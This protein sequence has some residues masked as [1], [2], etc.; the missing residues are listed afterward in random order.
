M[1]PC[2]PN[3][4][5]PV[6]ATNGAPDTARAGRPGVRA[7]A[8]TTDGWPVAGA[9]LTVTDMAGQ[10]VTR[11]PADA[12]GQLATDPLPVGTYTAVVTAAGFVPVARTAVVTPSGAATLGVVPLARVGGEAELPVRGVWTIDPAHSAINVTAR[13]LGLASVRGRFTVFSGTI[14]V[15]RPVERSTVSAVIEASSIDTGNQM[16][17]DHLRSADFL[18]VDQHPKIEY[19][20]TSVVPL[21]GEKWRLDGELMLNG[22]TRPVALD[23]GFLGVGEDPWGGTRMAFHAVTDLRRDDFAITYNQV[24]RAGIAA[25]GT[26]LRVEIDVEAVRGDQ[27]PMG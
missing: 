17:D 9:V 22:I 18:G 12:D 4:N 19:R 14:Q 25:I 7:A 2:S 8:R 23:L 15:A 5:G 26:T 20:G 16:R 27:L 24:V 13:H 21:G 6:N 1:N 11:Q 10:Q 3:A